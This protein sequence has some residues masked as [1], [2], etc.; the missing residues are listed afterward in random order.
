L[1]GISFLSAAGFLAWGAQDLSYSRAFEDWERHRLPSERTWIY[2]LGSRGWH[3]SS[4][5]ELTHKA[6]RKLPTTLDSAGSIWA[7]PDLE[8]IVVFTDPLQTVPEKLFCRECQ[9][10]P[11]RFVP[12]GTGWPGFDLAMARLEKVKNRVVLATKVRKSYK[13]IDVREIHY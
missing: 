7:S 2:A 11:E 10:P 4:S 9:K 6:L 12:L 3:E 5:N 8:W 1:L 13:F